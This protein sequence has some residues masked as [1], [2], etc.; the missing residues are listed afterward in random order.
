MAG[1]SRRA[2]TDSETKNKQWATEGEVWTIALDFVRRPCFWQVAMSGLLA[3]ARPIMP[4]RGAAGCGSKLRQGNVLLTPGPVVV[5]HVS[6][7]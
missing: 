2:N 6:T 3:A 1:E 4:L 7:S 5:R